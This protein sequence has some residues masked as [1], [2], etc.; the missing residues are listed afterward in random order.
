METTQQEK[1]LSSEVHLALDSVE[2]MPIRVLVVDDDSVSR[3]M[4][5]GQ[6]KK[7]GHEVA[8]A[9]NGKEAYDML[10]ADPHAYDVLVLDREMPKIDGI[11][12]V[13]RMKASVKLRHIPVIM[14]TVHNELED[15][16]SGIDAGVF[17]YLEKP[18]GLDIL[19]SVLDATIRE[20]RKYRILTEELRQ[21]KASFSLMQEARFEIKTLNEAEGLAV[22]L[23]YSF[24]NPQRVVAGLAEILT[25]AIEHGN[26]GVTYQEKSTWID[27]NK[28]RENVMKRQEEP[29]NKDKRVKVSF[30]KDDK[31]F[32][33]TV[34]DEGKGFDWQKYLDIDPA[35]SQ[36]SH[37]RGI[38]LARAA[39]FD[40]MRYNDKGNKVT[41]SVNLEEDLVW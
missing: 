32:H 6:V 2:A 21:H 8:S 10:L 18:F 30:W 34:E 28:W 27:E 5:A 25:N 19:R 37:G 23:A 41:V 7:L 16:K 3:M 14:V 29:D 13:K 17:Y 15:V 9:D 38:A 35:R 24:P 36:H 22:F 11:D 31:G 12:L 33:V 39:N 1:P 20:I 26:M 40:D 4:M